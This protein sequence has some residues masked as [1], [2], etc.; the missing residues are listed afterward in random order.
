MS[1]ADALLGARVRRIDAPTDSSLAITL[2]AKDIDGVLL[3]S[4][5]QPA[6]G[7]GWLDKRPAE[8]TQ[9]QLL[10]RLKSCLEGGRIAAIEGPTSD[11]LRLHVERAEER[12]VLELVLRGRRGN[13]LL[14]SADGAVLAA[15]HPADREMV[16]DLR[17]DNHVSTKSDALQL[18]LTALRAAGERLLETQR[19]VALEQRR[20][21]LGRALRA[22]LRRAQRRLL[23]I[24]GD[25]ARVTQVSELRHHA[26]LVLSHL[27]E[28][29]R[30]C[31]QARVL[32]YTLDPPQPLELHIARGLGPQRQAQAWFDRARKLERGATLAAQRAQ[33]TQAWIA[34]LSSLSTRLDQAQDLG[35]VDQ[36]ALEAREHGVAMQ[37]KPEARSSTRQELRSPYR[38]FK[39]AGGR[40][41]WVGRGPEDNDRLT[42]DHARPHDLWLHV[43]DEAGAHVVVPLERDEACPPD[44]LCDAATL[45]AHFSQARGQS[46]VDVI[47]TARRYVRKPRKARPGLVAVLREKVFRLELEPSR[48]QRL[49]K[50]EPPH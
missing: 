30:D 37:P 8:H 15:L 23:A 50:S 39:G 35:Q 24:E 16:G 45:A 1:W 42:L 49:L 9:S 18:E 14:R 7:V 47:Y 33:A 22:Q 12:F 4:V 21:A 43:R 40:A 38:E 19:H 17:P 25:L 10:L 48:L 36:L 5:S 32:D 6:R 11:V 31:T 2:H 34:A 44:L 3:L 29:P 20:G 27:H 26:S 46:P 28:L 13:A 41:I